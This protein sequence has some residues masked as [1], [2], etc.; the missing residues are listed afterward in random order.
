[1]TLVLGM[2]IFIGTLFSETKTKRDEMRYNPS[3]KKDIYNTILELL[4]CTFIYNQDER[5]RKGRNEMNLL[6]NNN[7]YTLLILPT[8]SLRSL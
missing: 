6:E 7:Q 3:L 2:N 4:L 5:I 8:L 1:M